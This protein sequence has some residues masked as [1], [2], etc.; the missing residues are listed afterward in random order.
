M[1]NLKIKSHSASIGSKFGKAVLLLAVFSITKSG[2]AQSVCRYYMGINDPDTTCHIND[3]MGYSWQ[4]SHHNPT[5]ETYCSFS[6]TLGTQRCS[7][8]TTWQS[9]HVDLYEDEGCPG[10]NAPTHRG[11]TPSGAT[12]T[13][14]T[15]TNC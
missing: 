10:E 8:T 15:M 3:P 1:K 9:W 7:Q 6:L 2:T 11:W 12:I 5:Q 4:N 13:I 14:A